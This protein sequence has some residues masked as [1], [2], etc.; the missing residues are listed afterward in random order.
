MSCTEETTLFEIGVRRYLICA[1]ACVSVHVCV[2]VCR[3]EG[4]CFEQHRMYVLIIVC[5]V[6]DKHD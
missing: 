2:C 4:L 5:V 3:G 6:V 1:R